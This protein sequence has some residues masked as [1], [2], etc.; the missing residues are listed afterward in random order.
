MEK[1]AAVKSSVAA[2]AGPRSDFLWP[3]DNDSILA[4][5]LALAGEVATLYER[6]D[7]IE[8]VA[9]QE[10]GLSRDKIDAFVASPAVQAERGQWHDAFVARIMRT[11]TQEVEVLKAR[12]SRPIPEKSAGD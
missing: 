9:G 5:T 8:R 1:L 4:I 10:L 6:V 7:T 11:L 2:E 12:G 3:S